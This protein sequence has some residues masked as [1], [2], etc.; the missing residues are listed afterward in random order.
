MNIP[1]PL[2]RLLPASVSA[3]LLRLAAAFMGLFAL[4]LTLSPAV[5]QRSLLPLAELRWA[6]WLGVAVWVLAMFWLDRRTRD[7][8]PNRDPFLIPVA[9]LLA[10]WGLLTIWR[11]TGTFGL[12]QTA[13]LAVS[14]VLF[15]AALRYRERILP[16]LRRYKYVWLLV[17]LLITGLTFLFGTNP[18]GIGPDLWLGCCGLYFQPSELLKLLLI[19]YLSAYLADRQPLM[20]GLLPLLA[21]TA[22]MTGAVLLLLMVQRDLGT[23]WVFIFIYTI[24]I[25]IAAGKRRVL[26]ASVLVLV[27][28]MIAGYELVG[29]VQARIDSWL[30]PW[31]DPTNR[32]YQIVQALMAVAAG[33]LFGRGPGLGSP[34]F[35]PV[36]HSDFIYT[37]IVEETGLVGAIALLS[38]IAFLVVRALR[39]SLHARDAYQRYLAI[40]L[41][42]YIASQSLLIIGGNIRMLPLTGVTLPFVS[43]GGSS[44]L[45]SFFALLLLALV[46]HDGVH[47]SAPML[48]SKPTL[49]IASLLLGAFALAGLITGWWGVVR[50]PDLLTRPDNGRR[51]Q[52]DRYV[53]RGALLDADM[54]IL[55]STT[56]G[57]G[58]FTRAYI[59]PSLGNILG[60]SH[61]QFG[62]SGL[63]NGLDPILRGEERQP[64]WGLWLSHILYGQPSPGLDVQLSLDR[65]LTLEGMQAL[66]DHTGALVLMDANTGEVRA[67][68]S[69]PGF[70]TAT[71]NQDWA[72]LLN[73]EDSP[74]MN[75][76]AQGAYAPAGILGPWLLAAVRSQSVLPEP[77]G[78]TSYTLNERTLA[79]SSE[80]TDSRDWDALV[81]AACPGALAQLG[82]ALGESSL[83]ELYKALGLYS[84]PAVPLTQPSTSAPASLPRPGEAATG[85][86]GLLITPLQMARVAATL[87]NGGLLPEA[88]LAL[89]VKDAD[90]EW[91]PYSEVAAPQAVLT[92]AAAFSQAQKLAA[93]DAPLWEMQAYAL[94]QNERRYA[95][96]VAG[97]LSRGA[98]QQPYVIVVLLEGGTATQA[99][100]IGRQVVLSALGE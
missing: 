91:Q 97:S 48:N 79:C 87:S 6:H 23:A 83:L 22:V 56:G 80:P 53:W 89:A 86:A 41:A 26:L 60:Y 78:E 82:L 62:Q 75:R 39:I 25:Y 42:A 51:G 16:T 63:E 54:Q 88:Q 30:N 1:R 77:N 40:G 29:L 99:R 43:Y 72:D 15:V 74:L 7:K 98:G 32:S 65:A 3:S 46:S 20:S 67:M 36:A 11:L 92:S 9:G 55:S 73:R 33:G 81:Q 49:L 44:M 61:A 24:L 37:S 57:A 45:I 64:A 27:L 71:L 69:Q 38:L 35:V 14:C 100:T 85:Q 10:G 8:L 90:G 2:R 68:A 52:S 18:S 59:E 13:W 34:G 84:T 96:Y 17:G 4:A 31:L 47:R 12:R 58:Q 95:W 5:R 50:G 28:A 93:N 21:P 94:G 70:N 76:T 19:I 66:Q